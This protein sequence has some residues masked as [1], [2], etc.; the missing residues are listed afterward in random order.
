M[1]A[2]LVSVINMKGGVGKSTTTVALGR[3]AGAITIAAACCVIDLDPQTNASIMVAG[4]G[5]VERAARE[6]ERTLD[7]YFEAY[8]VPQQIRRPFKTLIE[9]KVSRSQGQA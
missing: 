2:R 8:A 7:L 4:P 6:A 9:H 5:Q 1:P 3:N